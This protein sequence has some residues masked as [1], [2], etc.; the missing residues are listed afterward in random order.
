MISYLLPMLCLGFSGTAWASTL[1]PSTTTLTLSSHSVAIGTL[2]TLTAT[3]TSNGRELT[4][5]LVKFCNATAKYCED[6]AVLGQTQLTNSGT[7]IVKLTLPVG[8]HHIKA[9][10]QGTSEAAGSVSAEECVAV[11][12]KYPTVTS[13]SASGQGVDNQGN[14]VYSLSGSVTGF[15]STLTG[16]LNFRDE[17][18]NN[19]LL[20][21]TQLGAP[22]AAGFSTASLLGIIPNSSNPPGGN[23]GVVADFNGDGRLDQVIYNGNL[24]LK[25]T[26]NSGISILLGN[27]DGTFTLKSSP[28]VGSPGATAIA[29][30]VGDFNNDGTPDLAVVNSGDNN[31]YILLGNG[32][33]AFTDGTPVSTITPSS[34]TNFVTGDFNGDG[35]ADLAI[36]SGS[37]LEILLGKGDGTFIPLATQS[38]PSPSQM[39]VSDFNKDGKADLAMVNGNGPSVFLGNGDGTFFAAPAISLNCPSSSCDSVAVGDFNGDGKPDLV[40]TSYGDPNP[41]FYTPGDINI[42]QGN[43]DGTFVVEAPVASQTYQYVD[44]GDFNGDG[45]T[46]IVE[47]QVDVTTNVGN[48]TAVVY[49]GVGDGTFSSAWSYGYSASFYVNKSFTPGDFNNDGKTDLAI[50]VYFA[51]EL[52]GGM[53][54]SATVNNV[55]IVGGIGTHNV[56]AQYSGDTN[57]PSSSSGILPLQGPQASTTVNLQVSP[58]TATRGEAVQFTATISPSTDQGYMPTGTVTFSMSNSSGI[59]QLGSVAVSQGKATFTTT[60]VPVGSQSITAAYSG[61]SAFMSS[62]SPAVTLTIVNPPTETE[63]HISPSSSVNAGDVVTLSAKVTS[64]G[65]QLSQGQIIFCDADAAHC[66]NEAVLGQAQLT[67]NGVATIRLKPG[68]GQHSF[69]AVFQGTSLYASSTSEAQTVTVTGLYPTTTQ[70]YWGNDTLYSAVVSYGKYVPT[71]AISFQDHSTGSSLGSVQLRGGETP[72]IPQKVDSLNLGTYQRALATADFNND[73]IPDIASGNENGTVSVALGKGDGTFM[74][75]PSFSAGTGILTILTG[76]F[77]H[78]GIPDLASVANNQANSGLVTI[79]LGNGDGTFTTRS[80]ITL[81]GS[82]SPN[83]AGIADFNKDGIPDLLVVGSSFGEG[84]FQVLL[85]NGDGTFGNPMDTLFFEIPTSVTIGDFNGDG[86]PDFASVQSGSS[87]VTIF[88][89]NGDGT[90][91]FG[92]STG[93][94]LPNAPGSIV[95][96]DFNGD[97]ILDLATTGGNYDQNGNFLNGVVTVSLGKGDGTFT[98]ASSTSIGTKYI[99]QSITVGDFNGDGI[100]DIATVNPPQSGDHSKVVG[101]LTFLFGKGDGTFPVVTSSHDWGYNG[102]VA[103]DFNGDGVSDVAITNYDANAIGVLLTLG[104]A[105]ADLTHV[106]LP[107]TGAQTVYASYP[108]DNHHAPSKSRS[109][110]ISQQSK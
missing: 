22:S 62:T 26:Y 63:L 65:N 3:V 90:F 19:I 46:D 87:Y 8:E 14:P 29:V 83:S 25:G 39:V 51:T 28:V 93:F 73:G 53:S 2:V 5:G 42:L 72:F 68:I 41:M 89:G 74:A 99:P 9:V 101:S 108:G 91:G 32:D 55:P 37:Q 52:S 109:I 96:G 103:G 67:Q 56:F 15:S 17:T 102:I 85:G 38:V 58:Q 7:A 27:G 66:E 10:F 94:G 57:N 69:K 98:A 1:S 107:G 84:D 43:G 31:I 47:A 24:D 48:T 6:A 71:G 81:S 40:V 12:G 54:A 80:T 16:T 82:L 86:I 106:T 35:N 50:P 61:D 33:G 30:V 105:V 11:T 95:T 110:S 49:L 34:Q 75:K 92:V 70:L 100:A 76:D 45:I 77:N 60:S 23:A 88:L 97:G 79:F 59:T 36:A 18:E 104:T 4:P 64:A 78:D 44:V 13:I 20:A 21:S